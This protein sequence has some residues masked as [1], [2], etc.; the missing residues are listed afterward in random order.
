MRSFYST[1]ALMLMAVS[2]QAAPSYQVVK[3]ISLPGDGGWDYITLDPEARRLYIT[4]STQVQVFDIDQEKLIGQITPT[5]GVHGVALAPGL[6]RGF[7]SNG[8][9]GTVTIFDIKDLRILDRVAVG[10]KNP[11][12]IVFDPRTHQVFTFNGKSNDATVIEAANGKVVKRIELGGR[13]EFAVADGDGFLYVDLEDAS[14]LLKIDTNQLKVVARWPLAPCEEPSSLAMDRPS[15]RLF[16]G[17]RNKVMAVVDAASGRVVATSPIGEHVDATLFDVNAGQIF[18]I[19]GDGT[20]TVIQ[21][22][23]LDT[24]HVVETV[25]TERGAR[26]GALDPK[27]HR[28]YLPYAERGPEPRPTSDLSHPRPSIKPGTFALLVLQP[29]GK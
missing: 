29:T 9:D 16:V 7:T 25:P 20:V 6:G 18:S 14:H 1:F 8:Q 24:Y 10:G 22:D 23:S 12:T 21:E 27:T 2:L 15:N 19:N 5:Q 11:D 26:T 28:L 4:H 17:C 3:K 13:P